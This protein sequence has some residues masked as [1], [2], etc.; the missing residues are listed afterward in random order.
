[1][2]GLGN[3]KNEMVLAV[4]EGDGVEA[5]PGSVAL[6]RRLRSEG[7]RI[8]VVSSSRS[9][10]AVLRAA[11]ILELFELWVDG[12]VAAARGLPGKPAPDTF[13]EAAR[14]MDIDPSRAVVVEDA[15][16]GVRAGRAGGFGL[17]IGV[18]R[19]DDADALYQ[20]G[21]DRVVDDLAE[22]I[23]DDS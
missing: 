21:A 18:N 2:W 1:M 17:V 11:G 7:R 13:L 9:C 19:H 20:H 23:P 3:Q 15:L 5:Y 4:L 16:S 10:E 12:N 22:L 6:V 14:E 8:A